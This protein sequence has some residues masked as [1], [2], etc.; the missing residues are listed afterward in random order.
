MDVCNSYPLGVYVR[1]PGKDCLKIANFSE[2]SI[3]ALYLK[4]GLEV[5]NSFPPV[6]YVRI[7]GKGCLKIANFCQISIFALYLKVGL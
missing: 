5:S 4:V 3:F 6:A 7:P 1:I 2:I